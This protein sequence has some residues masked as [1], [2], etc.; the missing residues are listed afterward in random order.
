[1]A[2]VRESMTFPDLPQLGDEVRLDFTSPPQSQATP[3]PHP[4]GAQ[5]QQ[6]TP[7][8]QQQQQQAP[9]TANKP[10][11][12]PTAPKPPAPKPKAGGVDF[13][14]YQFPVEDE[15][16]AGSEDTA[17]PPPPSTPPR[18]HRVSAFKKEGPS[19]KKTPAFQE[20]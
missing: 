8:Q 15:E 3:K 11:P 18:Q 6:T 20:Q 7:T 19:K 12:P 13:S 17:V 5:S 16:T 9:P 2:A 1:M 14:S 4:S 10:P